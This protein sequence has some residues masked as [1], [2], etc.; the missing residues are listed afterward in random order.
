[1]T[2][3]EWGNP[4][5]LSGTEFLVMGLL[6]RRSR[7]LYGLEMVE[8]SKGRLKRGTIYVTLARLEEKGYVSSRREFVKVDDSVM[9]RR[10]Y[11][12][13]GLGQRVFAALEGVT[14]GELKEA[15][16]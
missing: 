16:A 3:R 9:P 11:K 6:I 12:P 15:F 4:P 14:S 1:M 13:T 10:L 2:K 7:E 5:S 8:E